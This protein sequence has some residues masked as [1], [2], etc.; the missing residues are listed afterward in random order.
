MNYFTLGHNANH[1]F[2]TFSKQAAHAELM[3]PGNEHFNIMASD[4]GRPGRGWVK[5]LVHQGPLCWV[6]GGKFHNLCLTLIHWHTEHGVKVLTGK[7]QTIAVV[8]E[9]LAAN[10]HG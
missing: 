3:E 10:N 4:L 1:D 8:M 7:P 2:I 5:K 6:S 9:S